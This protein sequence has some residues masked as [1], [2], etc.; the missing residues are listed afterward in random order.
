MT[1]KQAIEELSK[2]PPDGQLMVVDLDGSVPLQGF[3][4]YDAPP[5]VDSSNGGPHW[6]NVVYCEDSERVT[7]GLPAL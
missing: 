5:N 6:I 3:Q 4:D 1:V 7:N 2:L